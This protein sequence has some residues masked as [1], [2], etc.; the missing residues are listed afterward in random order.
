MTMKKGIVTCDIFE[1]GSSKEAKEALRICTNIA[2]KCGVQTKLVIK[3]DMA[4]LQL[5]ALKWQMVKYYARTLR[6][7]YNKNC[8]VHAL[9]TGAARIVQM[10]F[11]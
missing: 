10:I 5:A 2:A 6:Q 4:V 8:Q 7:F 11:A 1:D 3:D 9:A